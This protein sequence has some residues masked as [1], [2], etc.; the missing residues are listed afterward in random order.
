MG[1]KPDIVLEFLFWT[2]K[3]LQDIAIEKSFS[4]VIGLFVVKPKISKKQETYLC[5]IPHKVI[6]C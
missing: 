3:K 5:Q 6:I 2:L 1:N 4:N